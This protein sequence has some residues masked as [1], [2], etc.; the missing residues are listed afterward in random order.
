MDSDEIYKIIGYFV[1]VIFF[2]YL[3]SKALSMN[4]RVIEGMIGSSSSSDSKSSSSSSS[5]SSSKRPAKCGKN[6]S[7]QKKISDEDMKKEIDGLNTKVQQCIDQNCNQYDDVINGGATQNK[8]YIAALNESF[9]T[10]IYQQKV[11]AA[12]DA[13]NLLDASEDLRAE[14][15]IAKKI[16]NDISP[17]LQNVKTMEECKKYFNEL[18]G[19]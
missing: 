6:I 10:I 8:D 16:K 1:A 15:T 14:A 17:I 19:P 3:I 12:N 5:N 18:Y 4:V 2:I 7:T 9:D 11:L 13:V